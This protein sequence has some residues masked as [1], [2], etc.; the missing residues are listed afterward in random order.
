MKSLFIFAAAAVMPWAHAAETGCPWMN[1][2]TAG[3][4]LGGDV[5]EKVTKNHDDADCEFV[6]GQGELKLSIEVKTMRDPARE[7]P[8]YAAR[9]GGH[10]TPLRAIGNEAVACMEKEGKGTAV[11]RVVGRVRTR[12]FVIGVSAGGSGLSP[13]EIGEKARNVAEQVAGNLF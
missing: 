8:D 2:A 12:A 10:A 7:F 4:V 1:A 5:T 6:R 11:A 13:A 3:G 9:C